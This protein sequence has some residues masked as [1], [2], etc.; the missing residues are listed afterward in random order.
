MFFLFLWG[1]LFV[2]KFF[3]I[4]YVMFNVIYGD[5]IICFV[6]VM[7]IG[8]YDILINVTVL[9]Q[10]TNFVMW[11]FVSLIIKLQGRFIK[12]MG[13]Y[14]RTILNATWWCVQ[15]SVNWIVVM[16]YYLILHQL[17]MNTNK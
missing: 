1:I 16:V 2:G 15:S 10:Y 8:L 13:N 4:Y 3:F 14:V 7:L 6:E 9:S 5:C 17:L 12:L 11:M